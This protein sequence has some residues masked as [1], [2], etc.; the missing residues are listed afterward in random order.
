LR[1]RLAK[2]REQGDDLARPNGRDTAWAASA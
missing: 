1:Y 2:A